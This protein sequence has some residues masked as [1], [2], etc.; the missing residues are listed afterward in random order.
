MATVGIFK[1][2][3]FTPERLQDF[4]DQ[5]NE[6][7]HSSPLPITLQHGGPVI[8][9][10]TKAWLADNKNSVLSLFFEGVILQQYESEAG[11]LP[12][13]M[14]ISFF[15]PM[16][17]TGDDPQFRIS[18]PE[19]TPVEY[20]ADLYTVAKESNVSVV[21]G[22]TIQFSEVAASIM[23]AVECFTRSIE[24][25][26]VMREWVRRNQHKTENGDSHIRYITYQEGDINLNI[27]I[28]SAAEL[29]HA[30]DRIIEHMDKKIDG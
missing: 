7:L 14:S 24:L 18:F 12:K 9:E 29:E 25:L 28:N 4:C 21:I 23:L 26:L 17:I 20:L 2:I 10:F 15:E 6:S 5:I 1:G 22:K 13:Y 11:N 16:Y 19:D 3:N 30:I 8:G 27:P